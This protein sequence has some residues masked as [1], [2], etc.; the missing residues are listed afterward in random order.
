LD[1][2]NPEHLQGLDK[3]V[4]GRQAEVST[5]ASKSQ[6][7][8]LRTVCSV[9]DGQP[10]TDWTIDIVDDELGKVWGALRRLMGQLRVPQRT[11]PLPFKQELSAL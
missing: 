2:K 5:E 8:K 10:V 11:V 7:P 9:K 3:K 4:K 6:K 1:C